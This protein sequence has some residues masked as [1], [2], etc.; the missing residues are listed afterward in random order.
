METEYV[1][2]AET[3]TSQMAGNI[4][5]RET[6]EMLRGYPER[7]YPEPEDP[8]LKEKGKK[9]RPTSRANLSGCVSMKFEVSTAGLLEPWPG[10]TAQTRLM[11]WQRARS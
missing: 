3:L 1:A 7:D 5:A 4:K 9:G 11:A 8:N 10:S 2:H 6:L